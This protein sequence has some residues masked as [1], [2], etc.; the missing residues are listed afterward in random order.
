MAITIIN[1]WD[2]EAPKNPNPNELWVNHETGMIERPGQASI[3]LNGPTSGS[4]YEQLKAK[5][6]E[7]RAMMLRIKREMLSV[8]KCPQCGWQG[9][10]DG[11][12]ANRNL[13]ACRI[14]RAK[15]HGVETELLVCP[16][17]RCDSPVL[18]IQ[19]AADLRIA[20]GGRI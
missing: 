20:P 6:V 12:Q 2:A 3:A 7:A 13:G 17:T 15:L 4:E 10:G 11:T 8:H 1:K 5:E 9:R 19:D 16:N 14:K 18:R